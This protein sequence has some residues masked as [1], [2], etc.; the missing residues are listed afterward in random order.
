MQG[1]ARPPHASL[2]EYVGLDPALGVIAAH[3][4]AAGGQRVAV[5]ELEVGVLLAE[6]GHRERGLVHRREAD[7]ALAVGL[8]LGEFALH[9]AEELDSRAAHRFAAEDVHHCDAVALVSVPCHHG[10]IACEQVHAPLL[11]GLV[12]TEISVA[13]PESFL[14]ERFAPADFNMVDSA[15]LGTNHLVEAEAVG[16]VAADLLRVRRAE[17][18][19]RVR[20]GL[21]HPVEVVAALVVAELKELQDVVAIDLLDP[22][23]G[24]GIAHGAEKQVELAA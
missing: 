8:T 14:H 4:E 7:R 20:Q 23:L 2:P 16:A 5:V 18:Y 13:V 24:L 17:H 15:R 3:I 10:Y 19:G 9:E 12:V 21:R 22:H 6:S 1:V 11:I